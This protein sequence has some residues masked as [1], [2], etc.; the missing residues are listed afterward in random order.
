M[1]GWGAR[2]GGWGLQGGGIFCDGQKKA[3]EYGKFHSGVD[4]MVGEGEGS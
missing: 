2:Q 4:G 3:G 1:G